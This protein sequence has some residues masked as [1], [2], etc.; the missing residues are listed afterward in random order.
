MK[1]LLRQVMKSPRA[2]NEI[3]SWTACG[4]QTNEITSNEITSKT[5]KSPGGQQKGEITSNEITSWTPSGHKSPQMTQRQFFMY[6][7]LTPR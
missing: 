2:Q 7:H 3:T 6:K 1:Y 4:Q 5:P